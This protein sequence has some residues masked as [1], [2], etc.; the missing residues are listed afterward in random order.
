[1]EG[2]NA[3]LTKYFL[4]AL[5]FAGVFACNNAAA[6]QAEFGSGT[7][8]NNTGVGNTP[9]LVNVTITTAS[10]TNVTWGWNGTDYSMYDRS[11]VLMYDFDNVSALGEKYNGTNNSFVR[12]ASLVGN[13]GTAKGNI[14]YAMDGRFGGALAFDGRDDVINATSSGLNINVGTISA[15]ARPAKSLNLSAGFTGIVSYGNAGSTGEYRLGYV[16]GYVQFCPGSC[17]YND[18]YTVNLSSGTW[19]HLLGT[20]DAV[21]NVSA[22]YVNGVLVSNGTVHAAGAVGTT[23]VGRLGLYPSNSFYFNGTIDEVRIWNRSMG[24]D[25]AR[26]Q[27]LTGMRRLDNG[28][29]E[30]YANQSNVSM[31][32][33][34]YYAYAKDADGSENRTG[35]MSVSVIF[36]TTE[37][38]DNRKAGVL[39]TGDDWDGDADDYAGCMNA[40]YYSRQNGVVFSPGII[41]DGVFKYNY[42]GLNSSQWAGIQQQV[43]WGYVSPVSHSLTHAGDSA[44]N[45][46]S[47]GTT[48]DKEVNGSKVAIVGNLTLSWQNWFNSSEYVV[49]YIDPYGYSDNTLRATLASNNYL[50]E[51]AISQGQSAWSPWW[52]DSMYERSSITIDAD[53]NNVSA[54]NSEFDATYAEGGIYW[55]FIHPR[56]QFWEDDSRVPTHLDYIG[57]KSDVWY[58][59]MGD[60]YSYHYLEDRI[61]MV[62]AVTN[63]SNRSISA[64]MNA[65]AG[66]RNKYGLSYPIT[67]KMAV[68]SGWGNVFVHY[69]NGT[70]GEYAPMPKK[71]EGDYFNG[72]DAYR[73]N[74]SEGMLYI[75]KGFPQDANEFY[76]KVDTIRLNSSGLNSTLDS[77]SAEELE[78]AT[79]FT[80]EQAAYGKINY[81][82]GV[83][84]SGITDFG[85]YINI[86]DNHIEVNSS[87]LF[88]LNTSA[89]LTLYG[90]GFANPRILKNG[91]V[92]T[93]CTIVSYSAGALIFDV[94]GF[95]SYVAEE[96]PAAPAST[97]SG[98]SCWKKVSISAPGSIE[99]YAG[100]TA[101][102]N[103]SILNEGCALQG[104]EA[105]VDAP[106]GWQSNSS[107]INRLEK[108]E[109][110][111]TLLGIT[112]A[113]SAGGHTWTASIN[114]DAGG[115]HSTKQLLVSVLSAQAP[116]G[117][118]SP[119]AIA[120]ASAANVSNENGAPVSNE[121]LPAGNAAGNSYG[122]GAA[123]GE[124]ASADGSAG[125]V[126]GAAGNAGAE[127]TIGASGSNAAGAENQSAA[128]SQTLANAEN[129][130]IVYAVGGAVLLVAV[131][132][133]LVA[134]LLM[135]R[136]KRRL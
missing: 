32:G 86:S 13:N 93:D 54:L 121:I 33:Y 37:Y 74:A 111:G 136:R 127:G 5:F 27:Y 109:E 73:Y 14:S 113:A 68:P 41:P 57:N 35:T 132:V 42:S 62:I 112:P 15:W 106:A 125:A 67:Y 25:E 92:C 53:A 50:I 12:D 118:W 52:A 78:N 126:A 70:G 110:W 80:L 39:F 24:A 84:L 119:A 49:A 98:G 72:I 114:V 29:W 56:S 105:G 122:N 108:N 46:T 120:N 59:G 20:Y 38:Y 63:Y 55:F 87:A 7:P 48:Y 135:K 107:K 45:Y 75:S 8:E 43:D 99:I 66:E 97:P 88:A 103:V 116:E 129:D 26:Q 51:R 94:S 131:V 58:A 2:K 18:R 90:L 82:N 95:S 133:G 69:S 23:Y 19:Y 100:E 101:Q 96:A 16:N 22:L 83:N 36:S 91:E 21:A 6:A 115:L 31:G 89:R 76:V 47:N 85:D 1:M 30:L 102:V 71:G 65:S 130:A 123:G 134:A 4:Y 61:G 81:T 60:M 3:Q 11:L 40:S 79:G 124:N 17:T 77:L 117:N 28:T 64:Q 10:L 9:I 104:V 34:S 128:Q 44:H